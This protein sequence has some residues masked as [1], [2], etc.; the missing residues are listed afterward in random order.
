MPAAIERRSDD[1]VV[2]TGWGSLSPLSASAVIKIA[3]LRRRSA[4]LQSRC[5]LI[6]LRLARLPKGRVYLGLKSLLRHQRNPRSTGV[7]GFCDPSPE[8]TRLRGEWGNRRLA[9]MPG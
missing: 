7:S 9:V 3:N 1:D 4:R 8:T 6:T 2:A 5:H